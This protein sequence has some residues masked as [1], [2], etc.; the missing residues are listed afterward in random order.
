MDIYF[1]KVKVLANNSLFHSMDI[2]FGKVKVLANRFKY[3]IVL[4]FYVRL[5]Q[6]FSLGKLGCK[7][8]MSREH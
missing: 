1:D 3:L 6:I 2:Y 4:H 5:T 8:L 7:K